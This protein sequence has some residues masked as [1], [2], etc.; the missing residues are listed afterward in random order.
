[1]YVRRAAATLLAMLLTTAAAWAQTKYISEVMLI[2]KNN[3][4]EAYALRDQYVAQGWTAIDQDLN[5]GCGSKSDYIFLLYKTRTT[6]SPNH[7][8]ITSFYISDASGDA[9]ASLT[10]GGQRYTLV[11]YDGDSHFKEKRGDLNSNAGGKD[12]HLYYTTDKV[13]DNTGIK[14]ISSIT[15]NKTKSGA[16][17]E[18]DLNKGAGGDDIYMHCE[19]ADAFWWVVEKST[20]GGRCIVKGFTGTKSNILAFPAIING[21]VVVGING[22]S[23]SDFENLEA[24]YLIHDINLNTMPSA[25]GC[26][27]LNPNRSL[28]LSCYKMSVKHANT[29]H[30]V[31]DPRL[32]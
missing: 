9:P 15:F 6:A 16:L 30:Y 1:M 23:F 19:K 32:F 18:Y 11:P 22:V 2:G 29:C 13:E 31:T 7:T 3:K 14:A 8:F 25:Q 28:E 10:S 21:V 27:K 26:T 24:I 12:I 4:T 5:K 17:Q 20:D